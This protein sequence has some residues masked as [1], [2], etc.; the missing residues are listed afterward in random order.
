MRFW[1]HL[2]SSIFG[3][4]ICQQVCPYNR[5][6]EKIKADEI[7]LKSLPSLFEIATMD[8]KFY[9]S[10]F[11]G[12]PLTRAKKSG[13][14]RNALIALF[15]T[16]SPKLEEALKFNLSDKNPVVAGTIAQILFLKKKKIDLS[17]NRRT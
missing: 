9:E 5:G 12:T 10:T 8:Q 6:I 17:T 13:L 1:K 7:R 2:R 14:K 16:N 11:G 3:C 4:D 15:V